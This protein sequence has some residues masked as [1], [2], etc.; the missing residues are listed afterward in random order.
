MSH[1]CARERDQERDRETEKN[2]YIV[3]DNR[4]SGNKLKDK[5]N[6]I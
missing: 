4:K 5:R 1:V 6:K 2:Q 3:E